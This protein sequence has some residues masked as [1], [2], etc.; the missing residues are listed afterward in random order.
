ML[1]PFNATQLEDQAKLITLVTDL[2]RFGERMYITQVENK[3]D[4]DYPTLTGIK[5]WYLTNSHDSGARL[6]EDPD[7]ETLTLIGMADCGDW[8]NQQQVIQRRHGIACFAQ[9]LGRELNGQ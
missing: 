4:P 5:W 1:G 6:G 7:V 2:S 9:E 8:M 3:H